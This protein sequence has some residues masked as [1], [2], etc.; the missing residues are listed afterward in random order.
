MIWTPL[1]NGRIPCDGKRRPVC[2]HR[3]VKLGG[4]AVI[5]SHA[6]EVVGKVPS[7]KPR[8]AVAVPSF[9][10]GFAV[11]L[12]QREKGWKECAVKFRHLCRHRA[13]E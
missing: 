4:F 10:A 11:T 12:P 5:V 3:A 6:E 8:F 2:H 1:W 13:V 7:N 9:A